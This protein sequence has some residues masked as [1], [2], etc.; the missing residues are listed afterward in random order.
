MRGRACVRVIANCSWFVLHCSF[1][2]ARQRG[3]PF[4]RAE[5]TEA[6]RYGRAAGLAWA[7]RSGPAEISQDPWAEAHRITVEEDKPGQESGSFLHPELFGQQAD[8]AFLAAVPSEPGE[9]AAEPAPQSPPAP[10]LSKPPQPEGV[11][12]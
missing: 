7:V 10:P 2:R 12:G 6:P 9:H 11:S 5:L 3:F 4:N 1:I 8:R